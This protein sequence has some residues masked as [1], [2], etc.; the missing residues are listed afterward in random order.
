MLIGLS[1]LALA[2]CSS[3]VRREN[4]GAV[5]VVSSE[6]SEWTDEQDFVAGSPLHFRYFV[7][8][9]LSSTCNVDRVSSCSVSVE[10]AVIHVETQA[11][12]SVTQWAAETC[13]DDCQRLTAKCETSALPDGTYTIRSG[14][15]EVAFTIP[16]RVGQAP[17]TEAPFQ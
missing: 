6:A 8:E 5:C 7:D 14:A 16:S 1:M 11:R 9:C 17:C 13:T 12:W 15:H 4:Q 2:A 10:G 3:E